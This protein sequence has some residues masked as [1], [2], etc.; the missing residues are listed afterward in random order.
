MIYKINRATMQLLNS[1]DLAAEALKARSERDLTQQEVANLLTDRGVAD[2]C[3]RQAVS[4]AESPEIGSRLNQL[5]IK[6][7]ETLTSRTVIGPRW[8]YKD[9]Q[10]QIS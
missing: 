4:S 6:I 2:S 7:I 5:R 9:Q 3:S 10:D 8:Y 1:S